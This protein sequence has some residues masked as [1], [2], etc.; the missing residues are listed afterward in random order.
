MKDGSWAV[1]RNDEL[2]NKRARD[3][4]KE[5]KGTGSSSGSIVSKAKEEGKFVVKEGAKTAISGLAE[6]QVQGSGGIVN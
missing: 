1:A 5:S 6:S 2:L 4:K 3:F